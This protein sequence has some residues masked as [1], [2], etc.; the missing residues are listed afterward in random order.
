M[1]FKTSA[2]FMKLSISV[3]IPAVFIISLFFIVTIKLAVKAY[4]R[5]PVTGNEGLIGLEGTANTDL[6]PD[7]GMISL[8]GEI[9]A[10][11][12]DDTIPK[13]TK[14]IVESVSGLTLK[15]KRFQKTEV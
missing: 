13:G 2:P 8:H 6:S 9:W 11:F 14:I 7:G 3:I 5:K 15:V 4:R 1:L 10:A 12:S